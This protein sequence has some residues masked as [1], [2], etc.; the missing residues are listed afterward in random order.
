MTDS[1][2]KGQ[3][4]KNI[5]LDPN[6]QPAKPAEPEVIAPAE[7]LPEAKPEATKVA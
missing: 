2:N 3:E 6:K 7:A 4:F 5:L 1:N